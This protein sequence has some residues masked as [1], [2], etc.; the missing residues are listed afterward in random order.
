MNRSNLTLPACLLALL[1]VASGHGVAGQEQQ[2]LAASNCVLTA[3]P[4]WHPIDLGKQP[5]VVAAFGDAG[6]NRSLLVLTYKRGEPQPAMSDAYV[7]G[8]DK[9][10]EKSAGGK[11]TSGKFVR[12]AGFAAYERRGT[13]NA[14]GRD[15]TTVALAIPTGDGAYLLEAFSAKGEAADDP[16][17][18]QAVGSF[19]FL[20]P[21]GSPRR[22]SDTG[23]R[24]AYA[25]GQSF[26][27]LA[28]ISLIILLIYRAASRRKPQ[29]AAGFSGPYPY[30]QNGFS[31]TANVPP[32]PSVEPSVPPPLPPVPHGAVSQDIH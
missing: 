1:L 10:V 20:H 28:F 21:P 16:E 29:P 9:G 12:V 17:I 11:K 24:T 23:Q 30:P 13:L 2:A 32:L 14:K 22:P 3:P 8:F 7:T 19:H 31:P 18:A 4:D 26:G 25:A 27:S 15:L 5:G 6:G